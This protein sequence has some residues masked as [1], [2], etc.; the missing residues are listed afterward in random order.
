M[1]SWA[2]VGRQSPGRR[3]I[4][5][6]WPRAR[7][8]TS[9]DRLSC[10]CESS[11]ACGAKA[12]VG[13]L[14][15]LVAEP[16]AEIGRQ[17]TRRRAVQ[18]EEWGVAH[19]TPGSRRS[20]LPRATRTTRASRASSAIE[21]TA[22]ERGHAI[23][24]SPFVV[25]GT[26]AVRRFVDEP[27]GEHAA[28]RAVQR[29]R[30]HVQLHPRSTPRSPAR[31]RSRA[32]RPRRARGE[33]AARRASAASGRRALG[34]SCATISVTDIVRNLRRDDGASTVFESGRSAAVHR[35]TGPPVHRSGP[36]HRGFGPAP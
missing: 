7:S 23:V 10:S 30:A 32:A 15:H 13:E 16:L 2:F 20:R 31:S 11:R 14:D 34:E 17:Q 4:P 36:V 35:S 8:A 25:V 27:G 5:A 26:L 21:E 18:P 29:A 3:A 12:P 1:S 6:E 33:C 28:D 24:P 9:R 19:A 22:T